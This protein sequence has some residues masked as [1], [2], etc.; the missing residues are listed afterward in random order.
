[1]LNKPETKVSSDSVLLIESLARDKDNGLFG[2][3]QARLSRD[4]YGN[5]DVDL[6]LSKEL[7]L[8]VLVFMPCSNG[9]GLVLLSY[10]GL[11]HYFKS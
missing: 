2:K 10:Y 5:A 9:G 8:A 3:P 4:S 7:E 11:E 6:I 1:V